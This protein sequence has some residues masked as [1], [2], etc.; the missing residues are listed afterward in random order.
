MMQKMNIKE[1][2]SEVV[3][4]EISENRAIEIEKSEWWNDA[5]DLQIAYIQINQDRLICNF[6]RFHQ[7]CE[8]VIESPIQSMA[9][10][11]RPFV[12]AM[13]RKINL[14]YEKERK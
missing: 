8:R 12:D 3:N 6:Y 4:K 14:E 13:K 10:G 1:L 9:F 7:A 5:T 11:L 2:I